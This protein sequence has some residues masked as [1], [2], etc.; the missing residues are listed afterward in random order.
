MKALLLNS[1]AVFLKWQPP[2]LAVQNGVLRNYQVVVYR[3]GNGPSAAP[4]HLTNVTVDSSTPTLLLTN[5]T[6]GVGY[7][8]RV[9]A[10]TRVGLGP[11]SAPAKLRLDPASKILDQQNYR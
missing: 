5:L 2:P 9:A 6:A 3:E 1:T 10:A 8:V 11:F 4:V 7:L